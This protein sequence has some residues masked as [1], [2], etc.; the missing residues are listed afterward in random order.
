MDKKTRTALISNYKSMD[1]QAVR[2]LIL[3]LS[4]SA[5]PVGAR[6]EYFMLSTIPSPCV[7]HPPLSFFPN[8]E[9]LS[10]VL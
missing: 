2:G 6:E 3:D 8:A 9:D 4:P 10:H 7:V 1:N 5:N